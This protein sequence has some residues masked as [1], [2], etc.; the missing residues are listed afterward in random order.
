MAQ[1]F[2]QGKQNATLHRVLLGQ[3]GLQPQLVQ[4]VVEE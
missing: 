2:A 1:H 4:Q 3:N